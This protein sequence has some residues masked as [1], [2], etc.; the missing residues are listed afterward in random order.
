MRRMLPGLTVRRCRV[1]AP[2]A[3]NYS[4]VN[5]FNHCSTNSTHA[6]AYPQFTFAAA[7]IEKKRNEKNKTKKKK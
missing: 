4:A 2:T 5:I 1:S 3:V 6:H 7:D